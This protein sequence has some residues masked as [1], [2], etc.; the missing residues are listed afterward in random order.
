MPKLHT[1]KCTRSN[2][3]QLESYHYAELHRVM[4]N[5]VP[6]SSNNAD[7]IFTLLINAGVP[8]MTTLDGYD[9]IIEGEDHAV[10][11]GLMSDRRVRHF[12]S[13]IGMLEGWVKEANQAAYGAENAAAIQLSDALA[14]GAFSRRLESYKAQLRTLPEAHTVDARFDALQRFI[15]RL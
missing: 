15:G 4:S 13:I 7:W 9:R 2:T 6:S 3:H 11:G 12:A 10:M 8:Y 14:T 1:S 5:A